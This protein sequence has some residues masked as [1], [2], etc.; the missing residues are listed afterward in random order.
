[1]A[2]GNGHNVGY[3]RVSSFQ[4]NLDRQLDGIDLDRIFTE[5]A[6]AKDAKRPVLK[7]CMEYLRD[8]DTLH[9]HSIDRLA[10]NLI[11]LQTIVKQLNVK[12]VTV[13]FHK[14]NLVFTGDDNPMSKLL[15]GIMGSLAEFERAIIKERQAEGIKIAQKKGV[16]FG[17]NKALNADQ[18]EEIKSR[19]ANGEP[20]KTLAQE[21]GVSRQTLY[22]AIS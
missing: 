8:G 3:V 22:S 20:K 19:I 12:G 15:L 21:Y 6:S 9:L 16:R 7:D 4:Q 14:E 10:R 18:V 2:N 5:K 13:H 11:D 17:R 1:M